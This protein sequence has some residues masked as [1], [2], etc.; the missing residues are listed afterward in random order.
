[1][2]LSPNSHLPGQKPDHLV[3]PRQSDAPVGTRGG[4]SP[5]PSGLRPLHRQHPVRSATVG[6]KWP[7]TR[8]HSESSCN[9]DTRVVVRVLLAN[10]DRDCARHDES[11]TAE[12]TV[13][14][15]AHMHACQPRQT[16]HSGDPDPP[17]MGELSPRT[18][19]VA[20]F[21]WL[22][23]TLSHARPTRCKGF[24]VSRPTSLVIL[25]D[26]PTPASDWPEDS[27][28]A[29]EF[30]PPGWRL[31]SSDGGE[32]RATEFPT[33]SAVI[34]SRRPSVISQSHSRV[35]LHTM[36]GICRPSSGWRLNE[37]S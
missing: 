24:G 9:A 21:P 31:R 27:I 18:P 14:P 29:D 26:L 30:H 12:N 20:P 36:A 15:H 19:E 13:C 28:S 1:V 23:P 16:G 4:D 8:V 2:G 3:P 7:H 22:A 5:P 35:K 34:I 10:V 32:I 25:V 37:Q 6:C 11:E 17:P 33:N